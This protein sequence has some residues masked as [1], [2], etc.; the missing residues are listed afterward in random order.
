M[1]SLNSEKGKVGEKLAFDY[2]KE[3]GFSIIE[4]NWRY[5]R[6]GEIDIIAKDVDT[7]VFVEVNHKT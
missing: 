6:M 3:K 5:S 2:L 4:Q 1:K 7:L